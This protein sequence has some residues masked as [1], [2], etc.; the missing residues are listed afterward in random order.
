VNQNSSLMAE[1]EGSVSGHRDGHG[2]VVCDV[3]HK[4]VKRY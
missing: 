2:F 3:W 1:I 4:K